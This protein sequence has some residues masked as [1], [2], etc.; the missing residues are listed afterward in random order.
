[1]EVLKGTEG[2]YPLV[3]FLVILI[4]LFYPYCSA[5][6]AFLVKSNTTV[7]CNGGLNECLI[8]D[9]VDLDFMM[10]SY[11]TR[12]LQEAGQATSATKNPDKETCQYVPTCVGSKKCGSSFNRGCGQKATPPPMAR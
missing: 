9:E 10:N 6:A 3:P 8:E 5:A 7:H 1:M 2:K 4:L 11:E 12:I